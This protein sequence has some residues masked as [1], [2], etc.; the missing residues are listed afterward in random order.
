MITTTDIENILYK[1]CQ[2]FGLDVYRK[3]NIPKGDVKVDRI[4]IRTKRQSSERYWRPCFVEVNV[5]VPDLRGG[6]ENSIRLGELE[7]MGHT[8]LDNVTGMYDETR[9]RYSIESVG[10]E[11]DTAL[12]CHFV[13]F[14]ILF[15]VLNTL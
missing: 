12:K 3:G 9:Y 6:V 11:A 2:A 14:R 13:N 15:E 10:T 4:V 8:V 1:D 5:S 7:R